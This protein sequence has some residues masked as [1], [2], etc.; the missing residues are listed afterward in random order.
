MGKPTVGVVGQGFV[1]GSLAQVLAERGVEVRVYDKAGKCAPGAVHGSRPDLV[2]HARIIFVCL[3]T[4]MLPNGAADVSIVEGALQTLSE[5]TVENSTGVVAV[6]KSTVPPGSTDRWNAM[7]AERGLHVVF[8]PEFLREATA[9]DDMRGQSRIVLGGPRPWI[10][11]VKRFYERLFLDVPIVKTSATTAEMVKYVTNVHLAVKVSLAN[12]IY[13]VCEALDAAGGNV[14]YDRVVDIATADERLGRSHWRVPG[15]MP[16]SDTGEPA[17]GF[18]GSC[19]VKDLN[20]LMAV[21]RSLGV[22]PKVMGGAWAKNLEVRP[23]RD[24]EKLVG[25]AVSEAAE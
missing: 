19:F 16:A 10:N 12:E 5:I 14:D 25:R 22:D 4:P 24:W 18:A 9:L 13:Q 20:A 7:F 2:R 21:A 3:P 17:R 23:Q 11:E 8:N 6:V 15:P 1:G